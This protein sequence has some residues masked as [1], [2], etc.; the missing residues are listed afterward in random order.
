MTRVRFAPSPTGFLHIGS[1][2]TALYNYLFARHTGG[3]CIL[4]VEDTDRTRLVEGAIEEQTASLEWAGITFDEGPH[5]GGNYGPYVQSERFHIYR[6]YAGKLLDS[7][8]AYYAFDTAE[9]LDA[10]RQRQQNAGIAPRYDR[11]TMRNQFTL[12]PAETKRLLESG[13]HHVVRLFVP[14][15]HE[16][17][18]HDLVR[19]DMVINSREVDDQILLKSDGF[20]TYHLANVVDDHLMAITHVIRAEEWLPSTPKHVLLYQAFGWDMPAFAHVPLMLD[21]Q[22]KKL[23]KRFGAVMVQEFRDQGYFPEAL[24]NYVALCGW[25]PGTEQEVFSMEDLIRQFS[26]DRVSKSGAIFDYQKL[27]WM[28]GQYLTGKDPRALADAIKPALDARGYLHTDISFVTNVTELLRSRIHFLNEL[29]DFG[30]Y[31]FTDALREFDAETAATLT[32]DAALV[33]ACRYL[34]ENLTPDTLASADAFKT[35]IGNAA[36]QAGTKAGK[37]MKP[38]RL[39]ITRHP[40]GA[41]MYDTCALLGS[42]R[43]VRRLSDFLLLAKTS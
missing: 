16:V 34:T 31:F 7:E 26:L 12:G 3:V 17:R 36:D 32:T 8:K 6:E 21:S 1:L 14:L 25:N 38:L 10:M 37:L 20:P 29:A 9:E 5:V 23:S 42:D 28:N 13:A 33:T 35:L 11:S 2:R 30:D 39:I 27:Q 41:E 22:R 18:F 40:V 15:H 43:I 4:R 24:I 19:G